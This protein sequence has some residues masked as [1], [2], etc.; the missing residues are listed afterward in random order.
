MVDYA[1][2]RRGRRRERFIEVDWPVDDYRS[3][4][5]ELVLEVSQQLGNACDWAPAGYELAFGQCVVAG[6][7]TTADA[8]DAAGAPADGT[9]T[10]GRWERRRARTGS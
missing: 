9:V 2:F 7:K 3:N 6:A 1:P 10:L 8:V 5:E 4:A